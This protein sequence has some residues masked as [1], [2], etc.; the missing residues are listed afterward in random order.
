VCPRSPRGIVA[1]GKGE[2]AVS[3]RIRDKAN[4]MFGCGKRWPSGAPWARES[5]GRGDDLSPSHGRLLERTSPR[6]Q[7]IEAGP[8]SI[9]AERAAI[10]GGMAAT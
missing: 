3:D 2:Q 1:A 5:P 8:E 6:F 7:H 10:L 9:D 4:E